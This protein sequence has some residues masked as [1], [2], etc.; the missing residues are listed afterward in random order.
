M[1]VEPL[2]EE[3][4]SSPIAGGVSR[5]GELTDPVEGE[6]WYFRI[7]EDEAWIAS[8]EGFGAGVFRCG[9]NLDPQ[10]FD[11]EP[12]PW[13]DVLDVAPFRPENTNAMLGQML[14]K[15]LTDG[16]GSTA[17]EL[18]DLLIGRGYRINVTITQVIEPT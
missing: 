11:W 6:P 17:L 1:S 14:A 3:W 16:L 8:T 7:N 2:T 5:S 13:S 18:A 12:V 4:W 9:R 10:Q 15:C